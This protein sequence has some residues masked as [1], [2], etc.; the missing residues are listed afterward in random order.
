M[1]LLDRD[2]SVYAIAVRPYVLTALKQRALK[3]GDS[4]KECAQDCPQMI[5]VPAGSYTMGSPQTESRAVTYRQEIPQ[6][7]VTIAKPF[8]VSEFEVTF[9]DW[10]TCVADGGCNGNT[11][12]RLRP[13]QNVRLS[14]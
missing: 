10:D 5:V 4:F 1:G 13:Q 14:T 7:T 6:H 8:A 2:I 11:P 9:A 3:P 12:E